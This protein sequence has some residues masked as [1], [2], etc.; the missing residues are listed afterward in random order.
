MCTVGKENEAC[1]S[2]YLVWLE[3]A[4]SPFPKTNYR[5]LDLI[6]AVRNNVY[7]DTLSSYTQPSFPKFTVQTY[8]D[9]ANFYNT[10]RYLSHVSCKKGRVADTSQKLI[11]RALKK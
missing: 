1:E 4:R 10:R 6:H 11:Q 7:P 8:E 5:A 2:V 9:Y 3:V